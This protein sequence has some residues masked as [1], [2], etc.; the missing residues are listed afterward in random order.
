[1][2]SARVT[3]SLKAPRTAEVTVLAPGLRTPRMVMHRCSAPSRP[4]WSKGGGSRG[5]AAHGDPVDRRRQRS[6]VPVTAALLTALIGLSDIV[7]I[8]KPDLMHRLHRINYLVPPGALT[9]GI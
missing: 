3:V 4:R 8:F 2:A 1:M 7:A 5:S 9:T 6:W